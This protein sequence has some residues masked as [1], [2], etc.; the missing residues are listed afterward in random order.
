MIHW[1]W[2]VPTLFFGGLIGWG[3]GLVTEDIDYI[4]RHR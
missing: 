1:A 2:L 4:M 3:V